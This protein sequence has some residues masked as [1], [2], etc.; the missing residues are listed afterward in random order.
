[1]T[2]QVSSTQLSLDHNHLL[3]LFPD[4]CSIQ[5]DRIELVVHYQDILYSC[6]RPHSNLQSEEDK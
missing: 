3:M 6:H 4:Q 1:M 5:E 2:L